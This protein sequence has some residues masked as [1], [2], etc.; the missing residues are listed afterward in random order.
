MTH[1]DAFLSPE[2]RTLQKM[3]KTYK[4][5][6]STLH[7]HFTNLLQRISKLYRIQVDLKILLNNDDVYDGYTDHQTRNEVTVV[8]LILHM[9]AAITCLGFSSIFHL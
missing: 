2:E 3:V 7:Q 1:D 6:L 9:M 4:I 8:P 5:L